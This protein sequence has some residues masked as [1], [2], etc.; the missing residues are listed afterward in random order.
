MKYAVFAVLLCLL[1]PCLVGKERGRESV[2][3]LDREIGK[4][5]GNGVFFLLPSFLADRVGLER[6]RRTSRPPQLGRHAHTTI[7]SNKDKG[8]SGRG[9]GKK[10]T[11]G[12]E[13]TGKGGKGEEIGESQER[14]GGGGGKDKGKRD[15]R[16]GIS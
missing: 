6:G 7:Q 12:G 13:T 9:E 16:G 1:A 15:S 10:E 4:G 3:G 2:G 11:R 5:V 8:R 14:G